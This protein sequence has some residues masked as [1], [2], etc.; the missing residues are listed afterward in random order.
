ML[1]FIDKI[2]CLSHKCAYKD[3]AI[4]DNWC[5]S[6]ARLCTQMGISAALGHFLRRLMNKEHCLRIKWTDDRILIK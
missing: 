6:G 1:T 4:G 2:H 3:V 5:F